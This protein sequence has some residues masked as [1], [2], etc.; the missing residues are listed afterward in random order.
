M[1]AM[2]VAILAAVLML[3]EAVHLSRQQDAAEVAADDC[4]EVSP[5]DQLALLWLARIRQ[6]DGIPLMDIS[7]GRCDAGARAA[8]TAL[9]EVGR[10]ESVQGFFTERYHCDVKR[11]CTVAADA[12]VFAVRLAFATESGWRLTVWPAAAPTASL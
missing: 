9:V 10:S 8:V 6:D 5:G 1:I 4:G 7:L 3:A 11:S 2:A 12:A